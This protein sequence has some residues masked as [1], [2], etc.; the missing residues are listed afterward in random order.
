MESIGVKEL[1]NNLSRVIKMVEKGKVIQ[2]LRHGKRVLELRPTSASDPH[3]D[4]VE[5]LASRNLVEGGGGRIGPVKGIRN[6][7]PG[8]QVSDFVVEDRR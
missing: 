2:V 1:R 3:H 4:L 7:K 8:I 5:R 6:R